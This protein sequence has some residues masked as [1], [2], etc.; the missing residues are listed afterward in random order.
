MLFCIAS[1][2]LSPNEL[3][4]EK[5]TLAD[6]YPAPTDPRRLKYESS[7][8]NYVPVNKKQEEIDVSPPESIKSSTSKYFDL[9]HFLSM[10]WLAILAMYKF[11]SSHGPSQVT[12]FFYTP[13][14]NQ[15]NWAHY[16]KLLH[17]S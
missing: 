6:H 4:N 8:S 17:I 2:S 16:V 1:E 7:A 14:Q 9:L 11:V 5:N 12:L 13:H 10:V 3:K 15:Y